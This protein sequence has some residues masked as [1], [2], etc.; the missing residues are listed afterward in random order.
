MCMCGS[1][2]NPALGSNGPLIT[3][4]EVQTLARRR[5]LDIAIS[6]LGPF[7]RVVCRDA[8]SDKIVGLTN[9]WIN[10]ISR[11]MHCEALQ[12]F[13]KGMA[14]ED[15]Q[16]VRGGVHGLGL[17]I[18]ACTFAFAQSK[19]CSR[20]EILAI[21]DYD[22][23]HKRLVRYYRYFG[24][25]PVKEVGLRGLADLVDQVVWG[26]VG[27]RMDANVE[28]ML[29]KWTPALRAQLLDTADF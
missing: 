13:T 25:V 5:N 2:R 8:A 18:G 28:S 14:G 10:P 11:S 22:Y 19:G 16:R 4:E 1:A 29:A 26:G 24:F 23:Q 21:N 20:A 3:I 12:V 7:Y 6:E 9:G 17:L 27:T 15:G